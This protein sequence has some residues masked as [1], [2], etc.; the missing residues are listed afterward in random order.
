MNISDFH[1][2][3]RASISKSFS[4]EDVITFSELSLDTNKIHL[5][6]NFADKSFFKGRI[7]HGFLSG[8]LISAVIA[9]KLVGSGAIYLHQ[10]LDFKKPVYIGD[11]ITADVKIEDINIQKSILYL[12]TNCKNQLDETVI[13]GNAVIKV[14]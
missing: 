1:I 10:D 3:Q 8:S 5:D 14:V 4:S 12:K 2:G 11:T 9:T 13:T 7:V 6:K